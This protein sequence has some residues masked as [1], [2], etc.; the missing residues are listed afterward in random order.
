MDVDGDAA[1]V[2]GH[3]ARAVGVQG[4]GDRV[5][6]AGE[7]FVD[8]V[9]DDLVDHMM[10]AGTVVG[11][12]DIHA[13]P[14]AHRVEPA[15]HLDRLRVVGRI[16]AIGS[17]VA[18][19]DAGCRRAARRARRTLL[20]RRRAGQEG[21]MRVYSP[22]CPLSKFSGSA[23][24]SRDV[25]IVHRQK[26]GRRRNGANSAS[27]VPVSHAWLSSRN[28]LRTMP[29]A[30]SRRGGRRSRR[31]GEAAARREPR[32]A[33]LHARAG[34]KSA[35]PSARRSR[36]IRPAIPSPP[37][38]RRGRS[39]AARRARRRLRVAMPARGRASRPPCLGGQG[40]HRFE[41]ILDGADQG[42]PGARKRS[43]GF[44]TS[45]VEPLH[46]LAPAGRHCDTLLGDDFLERTSQAGSAE[47]SRNS[48]E[49][50][51]KACS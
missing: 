27:S 17:A 37:G 30:G 25:S 50:S 14:L 41:P 2:I 47:P 38:R 21:R 48:R 45:A 3:G 18:V 29:R 6:I 44:G 20:R 24:R 9:V 16:F 26:L 46:G 4:H 33:V 22:Y 19:W 35:K 34:S 28:S 5:A 10:Q 31:A 1:A 13:R 43:L 51:R 12:A 40:G 7:R 39:G 49:R 36:P 42:Q 15:Q 8:R 23:A 32:A 11:V